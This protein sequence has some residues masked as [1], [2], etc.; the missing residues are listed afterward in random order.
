MS[1]GSRSLSLSLLPLSLSLR[2]VFLSQPDLRH[3]NVARGADH[4]L[5]RSMSRL[6]ALAQGASMYR[7]VRVVLTVNL[8]SAWSFRGW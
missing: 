2:R 5:W 4:H 3:Q 1:L 6:R 7:C 8:T